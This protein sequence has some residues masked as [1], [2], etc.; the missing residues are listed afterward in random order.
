MWMLMH[1]PPE[2]Q[3]Y[4]RLV[5]FCVSDIIGPQRGF[6]SSVN[7][8]LIWIG[9]PTALLLAVL[10]LFGALGQAGGMMH[11]ACQSVGW[12]PIPK[13]VQEAPKLPNFTSSRVDGGHG[14]KEYC[15]PVAQTYREQYPDFT[16][17]WHEAGDGRDKDLL[18]HATY[19]YTCTFSAVPKT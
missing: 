3:R 1:C 13:P 12:C 14:Y 19:Q 4:R 10:A 5:E 7:R 9:I 15:D 11:S 16:I 18:G 8:V 6:P 17:T 2:L